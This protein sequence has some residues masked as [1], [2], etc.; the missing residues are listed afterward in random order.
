LQHAHWDALNEPLLTQIG[1]ELDEMQQKVHF[2]A[3]Q[4]A[5]PRD[6]PIFKTWRRTP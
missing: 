1:Q 6:K 4:P 3:Q 2:L 5:N